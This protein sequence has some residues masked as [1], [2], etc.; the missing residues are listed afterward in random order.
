MDVNAA[1][2]TRLASAREILE[3]PVGAAGAAAQS[4]LQATTLRQ[5]IRHAMATMTK[6]QLESEASLWI[7]EVA[8]LKWH[9]DVDLGSVLDEVTAGSGSGARKSFMPKYQNYTQILGYFTEHEWVRILSP[10][11]GLVQLTIIARLFELN[12]SNGSEHSSK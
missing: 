2:Q 1:M 4:K 5:C 11:K 10:D 7:S 3:A 9:N 12:Y 6:L 8:K